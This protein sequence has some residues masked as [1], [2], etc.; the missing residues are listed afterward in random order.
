MLNLRPAPWWSQDGEK[1]ATRT[2]LS[3]LKLRQIEVLHASDG[4][5]RTR[6]RSQ[7]TKHRDTMLPAGFSGLTVFAARKPTISHDG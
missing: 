5:E 3:I 6:R 2:P 7:S 1:R 4:R